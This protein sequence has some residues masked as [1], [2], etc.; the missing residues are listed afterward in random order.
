MPTASL[1]LFLDDERFPPE[2]GRTWVI[3]RSVAEAQAWLTQHG[4]P[5]YV[6]FDNDLGEGEPEG[7]RLAQWLIDQDLDHPG[8]IPRGFTSVAHS[9]NCV[10]A[11]DIPQRL[12]RYLAFREDP[13]AGS[14]TP[15][16]ARR[17]P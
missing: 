11:P 13:T 6:S 17:S 14:P 8:F 3:L 9:Q 16:R 15:P 7:W 1:A 10:R 5:G 2:D 12:A 4:C